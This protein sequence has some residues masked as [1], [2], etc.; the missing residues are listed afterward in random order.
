VPNTPYRILAAD[1]PHYLGGFNAHIWDELKRRPPY[2]VES[3]LNPPS[4]EAAASAE[5][6]EEPDLVSR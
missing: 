1:R 2:V 3:I 5:T 4:R 6:V